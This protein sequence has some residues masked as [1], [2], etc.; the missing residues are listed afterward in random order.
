M[1]RIPETKIEEIQTASDVVSVVSRYVALKKAGKNFKGLCP[2][3]KEKTPSFIVSPE[4]QIYHC[5]GCG[6]GGNVFNFLMSVEN[7]SYIEAI[8]RIASD[9]GIQLPEY[10]PHDKQSSSTEY[11]HYYHANGIAKDYF[12]SSLSAPAKQY[13]NTRNLKQEPSTVM[14][15]VTPPINGMD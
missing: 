9:L 14:V 4:K 10:R 7:I 2:F 12:S 5:F 3:H 8:R 1:S 11:D 15:S 6:K 13:L